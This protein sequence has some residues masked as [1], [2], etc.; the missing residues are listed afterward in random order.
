MY[1]NRI[2]LDSSQSHYISRLIPIHFAEDRLMFSPKYN[3]NAKQKP[4]PRRQRYRYGVTVTEL[5]VAA[6]LFIASVS[7]VATGSLAMHRVWRDGEHYRIGVELMNQS[8][9]RLCEL[10]AEELQAAL[11][12]LEVPESY[13]QQL[14]GAELKGEMHQD[15][16]GTQITLRLNWERVGENDPIELTAW[17]HVAEP[18][19]KEDSNESS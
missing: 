18:D 10:S 15:T 19:A 3:P 8:M 12:Q 1:F 9:V 7:F 6:T 13:A 16:L 11:G 14:R 17:S 4:H 2:L 5:V